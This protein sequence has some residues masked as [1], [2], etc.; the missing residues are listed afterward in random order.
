MPVF[1]TVGETS[2]LLKKSQKSI[3]RIIKDLP[4]AFKLGGTWL[5]DQDMLLAG[6]KKLAEKEKAHNGTSDRHGLL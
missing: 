2:T 6:L 1:L 3:Y 5:V 4:G